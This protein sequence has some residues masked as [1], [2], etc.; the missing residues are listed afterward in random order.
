MALK[1]AVCGTETSVEVVCHHCGKPLC[2]QHR[3]LRRDDKAFVIPWYREP[4]QA[5]KRAVARR[6]GREVDSFAAFHCNACSD[7]HHAWFW[8]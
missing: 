7:K 1:C 6:L 8:Q 5:L 4:W 3:L 2:V